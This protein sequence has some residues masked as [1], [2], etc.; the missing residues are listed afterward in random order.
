VTNS[1]PLVAERLA[2]VDPFVVLDI[3]PQLLVDL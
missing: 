2:A 1:N 3:L